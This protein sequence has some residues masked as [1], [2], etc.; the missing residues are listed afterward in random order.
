MSRLKQAFSDFAAWCCYKA[1]DYARRKEL[2]RRR[3]NPDAVIPE[4]DDTASPEQRRIV[5][6]DAR[7]LLDNRHFVE[8]FAAVHGYLEQKA[9]ACENKE[10]AFHVV[11]AKQ[12]LRDIRRE[13]IRK[14]EDG[15]MAEVEIEALEKRKKL[16]R[17]VR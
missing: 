3:W 6:N 9:H 13:V 17:F 1:W 11:I 14:M 12:L 5:A 8:A 7:Q 2:K 16:T 10:Q 15:Y 4:T